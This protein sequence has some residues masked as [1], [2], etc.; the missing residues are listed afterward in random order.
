MARDRAERLVDDLDSDLVAAL[1]HDPYNALKAQGIE[2]RMR[3]EEPRGGG[4]SVDGSYRKGPP[5]RITVAE[6]A[7]RAR[8]RFTALHEYGHHLVKIDAE[9]HEVFA[10]FDDGGMAL[11]EAIADAV[12]AELLIPDSVVDQFIDKKGPAARA[13]V[14]L[15]HA[16]LAS[17]EA[18]CV[19]A[20]QRLLGSGYVMLAEEDVARFTANVGVPYRVARGTA[21]GADSLVARAANR[22]TAREQSRVVF[23]SGKP[24]ELLFGDAVLDDGYV[25]AVFTDRPSWERLTL[26]NPAEIVPS[27]EGS[28]RRCDVDF[29]DSYSFCTRCNEP[30]CPRCGDCWCETKAE[31]ATRTCTVCF[32]PWGLDRFSGESTVCKDC[33]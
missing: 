27:Y 26:R 22:G 21:Q 24:G 19:R 25:F 31:R 10:T 7:S 23:A 30:R 12:A 1:G 28:C 9:I 3:P 16:T 15:Y 6:A 29:A 4:C 14:D 5:P 20:A 2:L 13:I 33:E 11:E 8:R 32:L 18:T 17:R